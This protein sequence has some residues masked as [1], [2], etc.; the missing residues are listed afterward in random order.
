MRTRE[1]SAAQWSPVIAEDP[2]NVIQPM[3]G[4]APR[5]MPPEGTVPETVAVR[6]SQTFCVPLMVLPVTGVDTVIFT[7][8]EV[9]LPHPT[10]NTT[11]LYHVVCV[12]TPGV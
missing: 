11:R 2:T 4:L 10:T 12:S 9:S 5:A 1:P 8:A 3:P 7:A 6:F